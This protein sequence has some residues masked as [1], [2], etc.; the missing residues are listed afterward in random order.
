MLKT[1]DVYKTMFMAEL[2]IAFFVFTMKLKRRSYFPLRVAAV[3]VVDLVAALFFPANV[4]NTWY[5]SFVFIALFSIAMA[6]SIF[7]FEEKFINVLYC[8]LAAYTMRH[9]AFQIYGFATSGLELVFSEL[10]A[11]PVSALYGSESFTT[12]FT[13]NGVYW[14][15][16]Y[17]AIYVIVYLL[18]FKFFGARI[19]RKSTLSV[20]NSLLL[21]LSGVA[22]LTDVVLYSILLYSLEKISVALVL[23]YI[24]NILC[25]LFVLYMMSNAIEMKNLSD[26]LDMVRY[27][28]KIQKENYEEQSKNIEL[29]NI[30]C[31][32]IKH[33]IHEKLDA[34]AGKYLKDVEDL[35][36]IYDS[37]IKTGNAEVDIILMQ[38]TLFCAKNDIV[39]SCMVDGE[40]LSFM[41]GSD[42]YSLF[43]N[44]IDNAIE[45][46]IK[47]KDKG[48]R[49]VDLAATCSGN[50]LKIQS[51]N[52][53]DG[54]ISFDAN[55][56][57]L[58]DKQDKRF[59][60]FGV[61]SMRAIVEK[62][63][64]SINFSAQDGIFTVCIIMERRE[65]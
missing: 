19:W 52:Y 39:F 10:P 36:N 41:D 63:G 50:I 8:G 23:V 53:Y 47:F 20:T 37:K 60:G 25:C 30:R 33:Q 21:L 55:G 13:R 7:C 12:F 48:R 15:L 32:D 38:K 56:L 61:K 24:Y 58:T 29:I 3:C 22:L 49:V 45:S 9:L 65:Q 44:I 59:H 26:E 40:K 18:T 31:H 17:A 54:E 64:G 16:F 43:G 14:L 51:S 34:D 28:L 27:L 46:A 6:T 35:I 62:Y 42:I 1:F 5:N 11:D 2:L 57:P 4:F